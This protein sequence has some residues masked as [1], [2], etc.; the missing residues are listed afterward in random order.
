M[1]EPTSHSPHRGR[2]RACAYGRVAAVV[3]ALAILA[4]NRGADGSSNAGDRLV[5]QTDRGR[6][7]G[8][9]RGGVDIFR[10]IPYAAPPV[11]ERRFRAPQ[12]PAAWTGVRDATTSG[13]RC[14]QPSLAGPIVG[15]ED[16]LTLTVWRP[17]KPAAQPRPVMVFIHGGANAIGT[18]A[19]PHTEGRTLA[20]S[21]DVIVVTINYRLGLLGF[22]AHPEL[23]GE[24][25]TSGNWAYLDQIAALEWVARNIAAFGGDPERVT[26][27]GQSA[28]AL[29][30]CV[31]LASPLA[32]GLFDA[33][34]MQS[35][36][37]DVAPLAQREAEGERLMRASGCGSGPDPIACLRS[38][39][40]QQLVDLA[41]AVTNDIRSWA[42]PIGGAIDG[43]VL[44]A[45]PWAIFAAGEHNVVPTLV[46]ANA[47]ETRLFTSATLGPCRSYELAVSTTFGSAA[48]DVL[49][50]YPCS[51][52]P[53][54]REAFVAVTTDAL[55]DCQTRR[56]LR[57]LAAGSA[58]V[59]RYSYAYTRG[60]PAVREL[61]AFHGGEL[62]LLFGTMTRLGYE[63]PDEERALAEI[64]QTSWTTL[65]A[66]GSPIHAATPGWEPYGAVRDNAI[67][68]DSPVVAKDA[69]G[70][71]HCDFWDA[72][73]R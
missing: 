71:S 49:A 33:A 21:G 13:N 44:P 57:A 37:C 10:A 16:C 24:S 9:S 72:Q 53:S 32:A 35:G 17:S 67:V 27:F 5:V 61:E 42:L 11:A 19:H 52:Y 40:A 62:Q 4:C 48:A 69:V 1:P 60:D 64:M 63:L 34:I 70:S 8:T 73:A 39:S 41:P 47:Q 15:D 50:R 23:T 59:F 20:K 68:F 55:F 45:S 36:G 25:G 58:P 14:P 38:L 31:L 43:F 51:N 7:K 26:I 3:L 18:G 12:P 65:A 28:G 54:G 56:I 66:S 2:A 46:G 6:V 22:L 30:V 29:S